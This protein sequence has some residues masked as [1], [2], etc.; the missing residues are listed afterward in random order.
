MYDWGAGL[1]ETLTTIG[2]GSTEK[3]DQVRIRWPNGTV[4]T[5]PVVPADYVYML[6]E[7]Q[8]AQDKVPLITPRP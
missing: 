3:V 2:P 1:V 5:L 4:E 8:G 7:G 6:V